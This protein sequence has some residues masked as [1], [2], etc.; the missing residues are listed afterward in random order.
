MVH[1]CFHSLTFFCHKKPLHIFDSPTSLPLLLPT[2]CLHSTCPAR[3]HTREREPARSP[4]TRR[5]SLLRSP[6]QEQPAAALLRRPRNEATARKEKRNGG[7]NARASKKLFPSPPRALRLPS[8]LCRLALPLSR[9]CYA[10]D[11]HPR[12]ADSTLDSYSSYS[13]FLSA[14]IA[15]SFMSPSPKHQ[16]TRFFYLKPARAPILARFPSTCT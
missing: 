3:V 4:T 10:P 13:E 5:R 8:I 12:H 15:F 14:P 16:P 11:M 7:A 1:W 2:A 6:L 9:A